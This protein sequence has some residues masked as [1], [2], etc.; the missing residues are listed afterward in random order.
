MRKLDITG[1]KYGKL[2][3]IKPAPKRGGATYW[4]FRCECGN[5]CER[6]FESIKKV[7]NPCC[8]NCRHQGVHGHS[9][10]GKRTRT[11]ECWHHAKSR[12]FN[13]NDPK[14][15]IYGGRGITMC[16]RWRN[17]FAHF[18]ADMGECPK[19]KTLGRIDN[20]KG[21]TPSNCE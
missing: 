10:G 11:H 18:L 20:N 21:Y 6:Q 8:D 1:Q 13:P 16:D 7:K 4:H 5:E 14:Y 15:P 3:A 2:T 12:C 19:D 9:C 17:S